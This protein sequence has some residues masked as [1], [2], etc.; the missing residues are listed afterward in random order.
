MVTSPMH[1]PVAVAVPVRNEAAR[2]PRLLDALARQEGAPPFL[3]ALFLDGCT[4]AS[5]AV[6]RQALPALPFPVLVARGEAVGPPNAGRARVAACAL[7]LDGQ[8]SRAL[9]S[10]DADSRPAP[11]WIAASLRGLVRAPVVAGRILFAGAPL[12][13]RLIA[14]LDR[15]H[16]HRRALDPVP[17]EDADAAHHW[18]SAANLALRPAAY[19][20][21]GGF[22]AL[23]RGEDADLADRAWRAG[24]AVRRDAAVTVRTS[25]R[26]LGR[27]EGGFA[28]GLAALDRA[29]ALPRVAHPEDEAWRYR[30][31]ALARAGWTAGG[32]APLAA[33]LRLDPAELA[34]AAADA[35]NADAFAAR[36]VGAPAGGMRQVSLAHAEVALD[37]L[38][39]LALEGAA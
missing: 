1:L 3:L 17:W 23:S 19:R 2:L 9:L 25:A 34:R 31:H 13:A 21:L 14:Y 8:P 27:V 18:T 11:D 5:E 28:A 12:Q 38:R 24:L 15:L 6:V 33:A 37:A 20:A 10:T 4:D 32:T 36:V 29:E 26:R 30:H 7:A 16:A 39:G 35:P 22:Q